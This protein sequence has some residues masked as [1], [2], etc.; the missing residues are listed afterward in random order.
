MLKGL[1]LQMFRTDLSGCMVCFLLAYGLTVDLTPERIPIM[2][3][4]LHVHFFMAEVVVRQPCTDDRT[5]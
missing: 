1:T 2:K 4:V 5:L 3:R